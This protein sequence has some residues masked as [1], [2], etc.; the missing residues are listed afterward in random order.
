MSIK[1]FIEMAKAGLSS[2]SGTGNST[3]W[4]RVGLKRQVRVRETIPP[5]GSAVSGQRSRS[6]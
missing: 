3:E 5:R 6:K 2:T 1:W 4:D